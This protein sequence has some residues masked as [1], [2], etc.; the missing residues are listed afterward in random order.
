MVILVAP[1]TGYNEDGKVD[2][3][4]SKKIRFVISA[5]S[6]ISKNIV[7]VNS[8]HN[9]VV[10]QPLCK[11]HIEIDGVH[12]TEIVLATRTSRPIGKLF[13]L[14]DGK[15]VLHAL[16]DE[17]NAHGKPK[18]IWF[19]NAYSFEMVMAKVFFK[20]F[21]VPMI[22]EFEDW[23]FSRNRGLNIK[24]WIDYYFWIKAV[25]LF[26]KVYAIN[27]SVKARVYPYCKNVSLLP[28]V[29]PES[30][31][32]LPIES[33]P[34][35]RASNSIH[36]GYF[37]GLK[38]EKGADL[39]LELSQRLPKNYTIHVTGS[40]PLSAQFTEKAQSDAGKLIYHGMISDDELLRVISACDIILNPHVPISEFKD[41]LFPF[42]VIEAIAS[43]RLLVS[44]ELSFDGFEELS[45][46]IIFA[47]HSVDDF[48]KKI[49]GARQWFNEKKNSIVDSA[50]AATKLF[51]EKSIVLSMKS[52]VANP[53][54]VR[55]ASLNET[56]HL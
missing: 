42:K 47:K 37:G 32:K 33:P 21:F 44:T 40:G 25:G 54:A 56:K 12:V 43:G 17:I 50:A 41:G 18:L 20:K 27:S 13:N 39:V 16:D 46:G 53:D 35:D 1:Y 28:G 15:K 49:L 29:V 14:L 26:S 3:G 5:L 45:H 55:P 2:L 24:P 7:L 10:R 11:R 36:I 34:F 22:L 52:L 30:L 51:G 38:S 9:S 19:Y 4:A 6:R 23:H 8:A 31:S 48:E